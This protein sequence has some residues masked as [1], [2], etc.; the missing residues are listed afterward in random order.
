M[1]GLVHLLASDV[2]L[3]SDGGGK[4]IAVPNRIHGAANVAR[5]IVRS[6]D[7][8]VPK[9]LVARLVQVNGQPGFVAYLNGKPYTVITLEAKEGR[10]KVIYIVT[11]PEKLSHVPGSGCGGVCRF[12]GKPPAAKRSMKLVVFGATRQT[13][14]GRSFDRPWSAAIP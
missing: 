2:V 4:A 12:S 9:N 6:L 10:V 11:N 14:G 1:D 3:H 7:K 5:A 13:Q 8:L